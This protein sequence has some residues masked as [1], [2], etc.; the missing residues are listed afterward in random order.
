MIFIVRVHAPPMGKLAP[1]R[2]VPARWVRDSDVSTRSIDPHTRQKVHS[3]AQMDFARPL[4]LRSDGREQVKL[5]KK[6]DEG[7][8]ERSLKFFWQP[9]A[10]EDEYSSTIPLSRFLPTPSQDP[11]V[12]IP[13]RPWTRDHFLA[14]NGPNETDLSLSYDDFK[15]SPKGLYRVLQRLRQDGLVFLRDVPTELKGDLECELRQV[16]GRIGGLRNTFYGQT[17]DVK[18]LGSQGRNV[19]YTNVDLGLHMDLL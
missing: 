16:A 14:K 4:R 17:W 13:V 15:S 7:A 18:A 6:G 11:L 5:L 8:D 2:R 12:R 10:G 9:S 1:L 19:A 3:S